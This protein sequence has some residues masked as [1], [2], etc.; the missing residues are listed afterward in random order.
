MWEEFSRRRP[1]REEVSKDQK[2]I[3]KTNGSSVR[4]DNIMSVKEKLLG[5]RSI[6]K[7]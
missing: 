1:I 5:R 2:V 4:S 6:H 7:P 3:V